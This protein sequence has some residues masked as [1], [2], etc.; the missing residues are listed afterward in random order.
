MAAKTVPITGS[1]LAWARQESGY[2]K[3]DL[4]ERVKVSVDDLEAWE[5]EREEP[6]RGQFSKLWKALRRPSAVF[7]LPAAPV[8]E[9][10]PTALRNAPGLGNRKLLPEEMNEIRRAR[11]LQEMLSWA[12]A[13]DERD[14]VSLVQ[15]NSN[16]DAV[17]TA[18]QER[19]RSGIDAQEQLSWRSAT[20]GFREWRRLL[21]GY[22]V[23]VLQLKI[24]K[25]NIRGFSVWADFAPLV[26][27]NSAYHPTARTFTLFHEYGHLLRRSDAA[28]ADFVS[29]RASNPSEERWCERFA[30]G[31]LLPEDGVRKE[32]SKQEVSTTSMTSDPRMAWSL[33]NRFGVSARAMALRLQELGLA[34]KTLYAAVADQMR[35]RDW[36]DA[37][38]RGRGM[39][40]AQQRIGQLGSRLP[41]ELIAAAERGRMTTRDLA[42]YL[43]LKT[44]QINDLKD[45]LVDH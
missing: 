35:A 43:Q 3:S 28:C 45:L 4:A 10:L 14:P 17:E 26:A 30:A 38:G 6:T 12:L 18:A 25:D 9:G 42:D 2:T 32:A 33:A 15:I 39:T 37:G 36:N 40:A 1:V 19:C 8:E 24:G 31:F 5:A 20:E 44:G 41:G 22:G 13:D 11:R 27:V 34:D 16:A 23:M 7:F 21:E 29:P